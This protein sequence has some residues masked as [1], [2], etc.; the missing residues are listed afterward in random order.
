MAKS[1]IIF[2]KSRNN[3]HLN[4]RTTDKKRTKHREKL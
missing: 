1:F 4:N 3:T 2:I